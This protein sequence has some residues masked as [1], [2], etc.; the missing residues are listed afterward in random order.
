MEHEHS[1]RFW[2]G[3]FI[4]RLIKQIQIRRKYKKKKVECISE[5]N[6]RVEYSKMLRHNEEQERLKE[7][8][9]ALKNSKL[10][11]KFE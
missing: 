5:F 11:S 10:P 4:A 7:E 6:K 8:I 9:K 2:S 3:L 1:G